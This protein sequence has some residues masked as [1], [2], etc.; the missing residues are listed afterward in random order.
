MLIDLLQH[1]IMLLYEDILTGDEIASDAFPMYV[2]LIVIVIIINTY[3]WALF[4]Q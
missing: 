4:P 3:I 2:S 1:F